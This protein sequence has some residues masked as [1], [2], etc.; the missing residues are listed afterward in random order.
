MNNE[1][2]MK[3][4]LSP[5]VSEKASIAA[6]QDNQY[7]FKV[8]PDATKTE[9]KAAV[10]SLFEVQVKNVRTVNIKGKSKRFGAR[11]GRRNGVRKAYVALKPGF[12]ID[13]VGA[14]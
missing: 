3:V 9:I 8:A 7:V 11:M 13:L 10:E 6:D 4:L 5:L 14:Q 2:L 1:R 12:E